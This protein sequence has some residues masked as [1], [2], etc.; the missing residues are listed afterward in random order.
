MTVFRVE[1]TELTKVAEAPT[2]HWS[3]GVVFSRDGHMV[4]VQQMGEAAIA[5]F[6][7]D[8]KTL[9]PAAPLS[10]GVGPAAIATVW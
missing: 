4:L 8:G 7:F 5:V 9:T 2:G 1:G 6:R 3:Q 10:T